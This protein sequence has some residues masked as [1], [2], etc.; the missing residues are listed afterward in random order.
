M[1]VYFRKKY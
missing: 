1:N